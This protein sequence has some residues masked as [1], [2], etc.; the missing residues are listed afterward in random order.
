[1][2]GGEGE[3]VGTACYPLQMIP[4]ASIYSGYGDVPN[5]H[6]SISCKSPAKWFP[7]ITMLGRIGAG[8]CPCHKASVC[9]RSPW[10]LLCDSTR[11]IGIGRSLLL[12][13]LEKFEVSNIFYLL[14]NVLP[15][16][17]VFP[18]K[19]IPSKLLI[20]GLPLKNQVS[21]GEANYIGVCYLLQREW[22]G[23]H[24]GCLEFSFPFRWI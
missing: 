4:E 8:S 11:C 23:W 14:K 20:E 7:G 9:L 13:Y 12:R 19:P 18:A 6:F 3:V 24:S 1:M 17:C 15:P 2:G 5:L 21:W 22:Y 16:L 10:Y